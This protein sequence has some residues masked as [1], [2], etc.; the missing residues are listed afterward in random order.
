MEKLLM[1]GAAVVHCDQRHMPIGLMMP[2]VGHSEQGERF[3][4]QISASVPLKKKPLAANGKGQNPKPG[5]GAAQPEYRC[6]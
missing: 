5:L 2:L 6:R 1:N 3:R 4:H